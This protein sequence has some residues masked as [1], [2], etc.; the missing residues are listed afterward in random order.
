MIVFR[1]WPPGLPCSVV[2]V[3]F[4]LL[5]PGS[6]PRLVTVLPSFAGALFSSAAPTA[7]H[8]VTTG[9]ALSSLQ[10]DGV[11]LPP[12]FHDFEDSQDTECST[13]APRVAATAQAGVE[14][15]RPYKCSECPYT[16]DRT[17][18][19]SSS[20]EVHMRSAHTGEKAFNN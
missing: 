10:L 9:E 4:G 19:P 6:Q 20:L 14:C 1:K 12:F 7:V 2:S 8:T 18:T 15:K 17:S 11:L 16:A 3:L 13:S 5:V